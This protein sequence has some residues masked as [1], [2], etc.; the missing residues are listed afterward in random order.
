MLVVGVDLS[1]VVRPQPLR[2]P[3][4][5]MSLG[6]ILDRRCGTVDVEDHWPS[7]SGLLGRNRLVTLRT[8]V[9][10]AI[11]IVWRQ[12]SI[13]ATKT[14]LTTPV[15]PKGQLRMTWKDIQ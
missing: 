1:Q 2:S 5:G 4:W 9:A 6:G 7:V 3:A 13:L 15:E 8:P 14:T 10:L 12:I 11:E